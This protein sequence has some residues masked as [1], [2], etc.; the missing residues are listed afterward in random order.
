[1][2]QCLL[3]V[4]QVSQGVARYIMRQGA[5][6][7]NS[8]S[9]RSTPLGGATVATLCCGEFSTWITLYGNKYGKT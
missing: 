7:Q 5:K 2:G 9:K 1:M 6:Q 8:R 4:S 3:K